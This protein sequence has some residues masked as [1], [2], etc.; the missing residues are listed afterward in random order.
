MSQC[1]IFTE[2]ILKM[3]PCPEATQ[4]SLSL[5]LSDAFQVTVPQPE[6]RNSSRILHCINFH[7]SLVSLWLWQCLRCSLFLI[8][9][10]EEHVLGSIST[11]TEKFC[12]TNLNSTC[13]LEWSLTDVSQTENYLQI[14]DQEINAVCFN[15]RQNQKN[16]KKKK[17]KLL[18][19]KIMNWVNDIGETSD[20]I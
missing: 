1:C 2:L 10:S 17:K 8:M 9:V 6:P 18:Y 16:V 5:C 3:S 12:E 13:S 15:T 14:F 7:I 20:H 19:D 4:L 11:Q